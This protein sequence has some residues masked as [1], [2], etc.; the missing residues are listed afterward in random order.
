[1]AGNSSFA[2]EGRDLEMLAD[3]PNYHAWIM[4]RFAP[5]ARGHIVEFGAGVGSVSI[6]LLPFAD[7]LTLVEPSPNLVQKLQA[8]F[9]D[10]GRI[11][12]IGDDL[13]SSAANMRDASVDTIV[14]VNVLEHVENHQNAMAELLRTLKPGGHLLIFAPAL[15]SLMSRL[16]RLHGHFRRYE[17]RE[18]RDLV[19][20]AGGEV[21]F[22]RY[23]DFLGVVPWFVL[24]RLLGST[25]F[26]PLL[27]RMH[28]RLVV[29][30]SRLLEGHVAPPF[31]KNLLLVAAK[32]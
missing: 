11:A 8:R 17:R 27:V 4:E 24:N 3:M 31:G 14:L 32:R 13:E 10:D 23:F 25:T 22:C 9:G 6:R 15:Q 16:D 18:L 1:M 29:P 26:N 30:V 5:F 21:K 20:Q 28:D 7:S 12:V 19:L 2:Y